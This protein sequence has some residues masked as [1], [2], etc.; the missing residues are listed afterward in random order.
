MALLKV[1]LHSSK[2]RCLE[3]LTS[4][5][6]LQKQVLPARTAC[7][8]IVCWQSVHTLLLARI[9][10][11]LL[12]VPYIMRVC[13]QSSFRVVAATSASVLVPTTAVPVW[14]SSQAH[15]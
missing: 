3:L 1:S 6:S 8:Q 14:C 10:Y 5:S 9:Q 2:P 15:L 7:L 4:S 11:C 13:A 12:T